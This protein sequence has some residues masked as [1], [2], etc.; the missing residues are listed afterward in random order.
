MEAFDFAVKRSELDAN[1]TKHISCCRVYDKTKYS[2]L[3]GKYQELE[4]LF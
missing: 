3:P 2:T 1:Y 4:S